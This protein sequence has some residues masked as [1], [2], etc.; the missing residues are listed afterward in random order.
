M[1][2]CKHAQLYGYIKPLLNVFRNNVTDEEFT[3][4]IYIH[5]KIICPCTTFL[6]EFQ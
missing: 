1:K 2:F 3:N 6:I 5:R 4:D